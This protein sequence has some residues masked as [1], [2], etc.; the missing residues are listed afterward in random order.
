M[1]RLIVYD[2]DGTLVDTLGDIAQAANHMLGELGSPALAAGEIRRYVGSGVQEL[3]QRCLKTD[4]SARVAQGVTLFRAYYTTHLVDHSRLYLGARAVLDHFRARRQAVITNKPNPHASD[5]LRA[6]GV[7]DYFCEIVG[8][9]SAYPKKPDPSALLA[10]IKN[11]R[12]PPPDTLLIGDSPI[13]IET[14][15]N[16]G[17]FTVSVTH[18]FSDEDDIRRAAPDVI[19]R[20]FHE[21]LALARRDGW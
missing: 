21:L 12:I 6:L 7:A 1:K 20:D 8:G 10:I 14:G 4:D 9:E 3:V 5:I 18:G 11:E 13:D 15:R 2:L 19:V 17:V 16:A